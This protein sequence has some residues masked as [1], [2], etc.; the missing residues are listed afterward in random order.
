MKAEILRALHGGNHVSGQRLAQDLAI[1]RTAIWKYVKA[2][3]AEGYGIQATPGRGYVLIDSPDILLPEEILSG[4]KTRVL[5]REIAYRRELGSTQDLARSLATNGS[6]EGTMVIA[7]KQTSGRGRVGRSWSSLPGGIALS[8]ILRPQISP[9][10][11]PKLTIIAGVAVAQAIERSSAI[12][13][14][15]KWPN[16]IIA[17]GRK[18]GGILTEMSAEIDR[19]NHII[20][21]IGLNVNARRAAFP[22]EIQGLATSLHEEGGSPVSRVRLVQAILEE[23]EASY[24][25]FSR[26]GFDPL[27]QRWK[28]FSNTIGA[29]VSVTGGRE[30]IEGT[31]VDMDRDGSLIVRKEDGNLE[32]VIA[33]DVSLRTRG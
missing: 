10:E 6:A 25:T 11:A 23:L 22:P 5:G 14:R 29:R 7:E 3:R 4:L 9:A 15:L 13:P 28:E 24:E 20:I 31:A 30:T 32:R 8:I 26:S 27:L 16:D 21:G 1:S 18:I 17:S 33:G 2:L 12:R 19:I